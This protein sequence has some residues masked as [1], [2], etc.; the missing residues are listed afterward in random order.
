MPGG[1]AALVARA[2]ALVEERAA[3]GGGR[4]FDATEQLRLKRVNA[5]ESAEL[6]NSVV[7]FPFLEVGSEHWGRSKGGCGGRRL[8]V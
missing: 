4:R 1:P 2:A 3:A 7:S 5:Q 8:S 6:A